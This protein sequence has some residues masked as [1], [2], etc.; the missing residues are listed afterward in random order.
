MYMYIVDTLDLL[1]LYMYHAGMLT[2]YSFV[3]DCF[4]Y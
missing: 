2:V 4:E 3:V 1:T